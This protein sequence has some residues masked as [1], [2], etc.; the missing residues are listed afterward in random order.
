MIRQNDM[1]EEDVASVIFSTTMDLNA[2]F[3]ALAARQ[4]GWLNVALMCV[5]EMNVPGSLQ[6]CIR[7]LVH[8]NTDKPAKDI[9]HVYI[10]EASRLRPDLC[11][12]PPVDWNELEGWITDHLNREAKSSWQ[13]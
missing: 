1:R 12:L 11:K 13:S 9:V 10:K 4:L 3:P 7:I 6:R 5:H 8:W 2:E